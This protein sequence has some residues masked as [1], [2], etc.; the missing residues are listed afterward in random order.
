M[1]KKVAILTLLGVSLVS[2]DAFKA[3]GVFLTIF[4]GAKAT[5]LG[6]AFSSVADD[7][8]ASYYNPGAMAEF[9]HPEFSFIHAPW[10]RGL[11]PDMYYEFLGWVIPTNS[12]VF[13]G[14]IVYST[15]GIFEAINNENQLCGKFRPYETAIDLAYASKFTNDLDFGVNA[16]FI[17]SF[18]ASP[19]VLECAS[20]GE[21]QSGGSASSFAFGAG[22]LYKPY[23][24]RLRIAA[25]VDN[26][27]KSLVYTEGGEKNP[28]PR[29]FRFGVS[30][31]P[32]WSKLHKLLLTFDMNKIL[33]GI[34]ND[35]NE[36]GLK[37]VLD[38]AWKHAGI[39]YTFYDMISL[40]LGYF[41]DKY[42]WRKGFTFGGGVRF[43]NF[44]LDVADDSKIYDFD[45]SSNRRFSITYILK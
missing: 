39:E 6:A 30:F 38:E 12:G 21:I 2:A 18:L 45:E 10:L 20:Q 8:T 36:K 28:L 37:Y 43:K 16:K 42:G 14:H 7:G 15:Y 22:V 44:Q 4:P 35:Y 19:E 1:L 24:G 41:Y 27:G 29:L 34:Q 3:G 25:V 33:V 5:S 17:H 40:R 32:I 31:R 23:N 13:G 11:A 9:K 26:I